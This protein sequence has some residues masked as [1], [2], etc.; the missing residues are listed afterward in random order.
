MKNH[1]IT[2]GQNRGLAPKKEKVEGMSK[3][4]VLK[5]PRICKTRKRKVSDI[6]IVEEEIYA[7]HLFPLH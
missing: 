5:T 4:I 2:I 7:P 1:I 3:L 6:E